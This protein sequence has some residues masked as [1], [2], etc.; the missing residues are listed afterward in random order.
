MFKLNEHVELTALWVRRIAAR[1]QEMVFEAFADREGARAANVRASFISCKNS[2][3]RGHLRRALP[4]L[5]GA[6]AGPPS[7]A[8]RLETTSMASTRKPSTP[9]SSHQFIIS[10]GFEH[11]WVLPVQTRLLAGEKVQ[12][13][14]S[15]IRHPRL[16]LRKRL[17]KAVGPHR[18]LQ[19][20][21]RA[22]HASNTSHGAVNERTR[23]TQE[24]TGARSTCGDDE[25][26][27]NAHGRA[28]WGTCDQTIEG[29][30]VPEKRVNI[31]VVRDVV[32][33]VGLRRT[34]DWGN[35]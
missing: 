22:R 23:Q 27:H 17:L 4:D 30:E 21:A 25:I 12:I 18:W 33:V 13:I 11:P 29:R 9:R 19:A 6:R 8:R 26:H 3:R 5:N 1:T 35:P 20:R 28:S 15:R 14:L 2:C 34:V 7:G 24:T 32:A 16:I 10:D 31:A